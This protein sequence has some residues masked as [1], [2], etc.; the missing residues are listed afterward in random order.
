[1]A[2]DRCVVISFSADVIDSARRLGAAATGWCFE[3]WNER[4]RLR[5]ATLNPD[6][7]LTDWTIVPPS[8]LWTGRWR[9]ALWEVVDPAQALALHARGAHY[10]ETIAATTRTLAP[11]FPAGHKNGSSVRIVAQSERRSA[12]AAS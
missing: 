5:A 11:G 8:G 4:T 12:G 9:W 10:I 6:V 7:L 1:M 2:C 3:H